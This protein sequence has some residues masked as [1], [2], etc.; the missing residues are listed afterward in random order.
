[1]LLS[2]LL[3]R[4]R[5]RFPPGISVLTAGITRR[6]KNTPLFHKLSERLVEE[7]ITFSTLIGS[8]QDVLKAEVLQQLNARYAASPPEWEEL[9]ITMRAYG[10]ITSIC[11][12]INGSDGHEMEVK[13][14]ESAFACAYEKELPRRITDEKSSRHGQLFSRVEIA[15]SSKDHSQSSLLMSHACLYLAISGGWMKR[16][17]QESREYRVP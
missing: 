7:G 8:E 1:M 16:R 5:M 2:I 13:V 14:S 4:F 12:T 11:L 6:W 10:G 3:P 15:A 17:R 9:T